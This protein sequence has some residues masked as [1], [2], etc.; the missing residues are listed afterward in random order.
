MIPH[1]HKKRVTQ[2]LIYTDTVSMME[3]SV[4]R[5]RVCLKTPKQVLLLSVRAK[6]IARSA[7]KDESWQCTGEGIRIGIASS[8]S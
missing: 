4:I 3:V 2:C 5:L 7:S 8:M 6:S 1:I